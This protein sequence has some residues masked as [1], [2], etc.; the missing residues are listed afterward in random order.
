MSEEA[1]SLD[2]LREKLEFFRQQEA[3]CSDPE[4]KFGLK[5][6]IEA[7][8]QQ[9]GL[10]TTAGE[11]NDLI[12]TDLTHLPAGAAHFLGRDNELAALD[13]AWASAGNTALVELIAPGGTGKT[14]LVKRWLEHVKTDNWH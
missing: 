1:P 3:I 8:E 9:L 14:A 10:R 2:L 6:K 4:T 5:K 13:A 12:P 7:L 11:E